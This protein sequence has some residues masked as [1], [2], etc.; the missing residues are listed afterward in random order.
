M[1]L[2]QNVNL[3]NLPT[4]ADKLFGRLG[5]LE[6]NLKKFQNIFWDSYSLEMRKWLIWRNSGRKLKIDDVVYILDKKNGETR[7]NQLGLVK[8]ICSNRTYNIEYVQKSMKV[9]PKTFEI[10]KLPRNQ[11][12]QFKMVMNK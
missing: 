8:K 9:D 7:Q 11:L 10:K 5:K 12:S 6:Q 4:K 1:S 2:N 3:E